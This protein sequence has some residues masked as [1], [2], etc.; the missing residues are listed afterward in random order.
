MNRPNQ[1]RRRFLKVA[2]TATG[3]AAAGLMT[4]EALAAKASQSA[5]QYQ[6]QPKNG[7]VCAQCK[8]YIA[9]QSG[10]QGKCEVV[11]GAIVAQGW[12]VLYVAK[13]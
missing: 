7:Q 1:S 2:A 13:G 3:A 8:Y 12:C 11:Q 5:A 4:T 6:D 9:P 10:G